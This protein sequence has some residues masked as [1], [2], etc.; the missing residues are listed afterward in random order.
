MQVAGNHASLVNS[1]HLLVAKEF[2]SRI[3]TKKYVA[4]S[5]T[6]R[7]KQMTANGLNL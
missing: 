4:F 1:I 2:F 3:V 6:R 7:L 5:S